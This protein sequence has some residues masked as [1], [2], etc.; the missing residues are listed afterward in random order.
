VL[1]GAGDRA[2]LGRIGAGR[3]FEEPPAPAGHRRLALGPAHTPGGLLF[4]RPRAG[5]PATAFVALP[6][7]ERLLRV[8][9]GEPARTDVLLRDA[10]GRIGD[11]VQGDAGVLFIA[12][13]NR[14]GRGNVRDDDDLVVRL[15]PRKEGR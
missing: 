3:D 11:I 15:T 9:L 7:S 14:D 10:V 13:R 12:T 6:D 8:S 4:Y 1:S 2:T 5:G